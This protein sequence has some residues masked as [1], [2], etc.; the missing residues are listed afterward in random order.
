MNNTY[1]TKSE[2]I[3]VLKSKAEKWDIIAKSELADQVK[4]I[5]QNIS[6]AQIEC[7]CLQQFVI[8]CVDENEDNMENLPHIRYATKRLM[9]IVNAVFYNKEKL[10]DILP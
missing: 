7:S 5:L 3:E 2:M 9:D 10:A 8:D 4:E 6:L 1:S